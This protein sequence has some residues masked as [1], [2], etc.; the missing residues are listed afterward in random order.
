MTIA[1]I[2]DVVIEGMSS[3]RIIPMGKKRLIF[4]LF[5]GASDDVINYLLECRSLN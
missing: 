2:N 1:H 5:E 4:Q 3:W